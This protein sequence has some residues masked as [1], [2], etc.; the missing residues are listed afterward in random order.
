MTPIRML[1]GLLLIPVGLLAQ[2]TP[3]EVQSREWTEKS[4]PQGVTISNSDKYVDYRRDGKIVFRATER[5]VTLT[6]KS[7]QEASKA[8]QHLIE[9]VADGSVFASVMLDGASALNWTVVSGKPVYFTSGSVA[10]GEKRRFF[11]VCVPHHDYYE[12]VEVNGTEVK[13]SPETADSYAASKRAFIRMTERGI[14]HKLGNEQLLDSEKR[15]P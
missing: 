4:P 13:L 6:W 3:S 2:P 12:Y 9:F 1:L 11:H 14:M 5:T 15:Q 8:T 7:N 10:L